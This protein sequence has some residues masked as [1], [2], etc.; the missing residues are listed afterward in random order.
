MKRQR[1]NIGCSGWYYQ[2]WKGA[3]YPASLPSSQWFGHYQRTFDTVELNAPFY[4]WP[5]LTTVQ[6]WTRQAKPGFRY[7]VKVNRH[8]THLKRFNGTNTLVREFCGFANVLGEHMGCFLFQ[9]PPSFQYTAAR[10]RSI[11]SQL[12]PRRRHAVEFRHRSW[13]NDDVFAAFR[14]AGLI[15]CSVSAPRLPGD[16]IQTA[17]AVYLRFHGTQQWYRHDYSEAEL[18]TWAKKIRASRAKEVWAYFNND[19]QGCAF[20]NAQALRSLLS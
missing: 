12:D 15:F 6:N 14:S 18:E 19:F 11:V 17:D 2:H 3:V 7:S 9:L 4:H 20:R 13:W 10:L 1:I 8:I 16:V 5:R